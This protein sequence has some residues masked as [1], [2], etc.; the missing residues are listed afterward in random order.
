MSRKN[1]YHLDPAMKVFTDWKPRHFFR[2][3]DYSWFVSKLSQAEWQKRSGKKPSSDQTS[4]Q[5]KDDQ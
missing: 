4:H 5:G 1:F 3:Y 2:E